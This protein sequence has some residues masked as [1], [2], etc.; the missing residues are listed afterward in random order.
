MA[1]HKKKRRTEAFDA[2]SRRKKSRREYWGTVYG[3]RIDEHGQNIKINTLQEH[4]RTLCGDAFVITSTVFNVRWKH[5][6][7]HRTTNHHYHGATTM[8]QVVSCHIPCRFFKDALIVS[9]MSISTGS[10]QLTKKSMN[11]H[12]RSILNRTRPIVNL[13]TEIWT[14]CYV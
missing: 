13:H 6:R 7:H 11:A 9:S 5:Y 3:C 2:A 8:I 12:S 4:R 1:F 14:G 10:F